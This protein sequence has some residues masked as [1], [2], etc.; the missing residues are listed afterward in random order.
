[1][2]FLSLSLLP[3]YSL[4]VALGSNVD[5]I[6]AN[7]YTT[8]SSLLFSQ[9]HLL[10]NLHLWV[11]SVAWCLLFIVSWFNE[12]Q[13]ESNSGRMTLRVQKTFIIAFKIFVISEVMIFFCCFWAFL[14]FGFIPNVWILMIFP[15]LGILPILPFGIPLANVLI[16]LYSSLPLQAAQIWMKRGVKSRSLQLLFQTFTCGMLFLFLQLKEYT[17]ALF[18]ISDS[19][20]GSAFYCTTG[21]HG[22]HVTLGTLAFCCIWYLIH[23]DKIYNELHFSLKLWSIYWHFVDFLWICLFVIFYLWG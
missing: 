19:I 20:Y 10:N 9:Q 16:L 23:R 15:P 17:S 1:M 2:L 5:I 18:T 4:G 21:L 7:A 22:L 8:E 13:I 3:Y 11:P 14:H 6:L 12:L